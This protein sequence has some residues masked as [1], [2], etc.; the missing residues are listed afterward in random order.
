MTTAWIYWGIGIFFCISGVFVF[1]KSVYEK[2]RK[3]AP[4]FLLLLMGVVLIGIGT[5]RY[6]NLI[7]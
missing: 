4:S 2:E 6:F 3:L 1:F 7:H 5:A